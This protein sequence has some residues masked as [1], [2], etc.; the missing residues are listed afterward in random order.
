MSARFRALLFFAVASCATS[1]VSLTGE[2]KYGKSAEEDYQAGNEE[3]KKHNFAEATKFFEH[4]RTKY[5]F[6]KYA[7]LADLRIADARFDQGHYLEAAESYQQFV[8]LHPNHEQADYAAYRVGLSHFK[9]APSE[10]ILFPPTYEKDQAQIRDAARTLD[11]FV[12]KYPESTYRPDAEKLFAQARARLA[13]HEWY[14]AQ[15]YAKR[16]H[17][18]GAAGRLETLLREYPGSPREAAALYQLA[19]LYLKQDERYRAQQKLQEL[20]VKYPQDAR[21]AQAEKL[22]ASLR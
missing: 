5:P 20:I 10:F 21:R 14:V 1:H 8:K 12:R 18:A 7:A 17:W 2:L 22:L 16:E 15:F 3:L 9:D 6:S 4:V 19:E 11:E 13:E